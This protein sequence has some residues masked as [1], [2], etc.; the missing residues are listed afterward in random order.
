MT[1]AAI[2][3][4]GIAAICFGT[5]ILLMYK[6]VWP[7]AQ[8]WLML[9]AGLGMAG[10]MFGV[11]VDKLDVHPMAVILGHLS[12]KPQ[13]QL[14]PRTTP[15]SSRPGSSSPRAALR[16]SGTSP[17]CLSV[18][19]ARSSLT[20]SEDLPSTGSRSANHAKRI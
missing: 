2:G 12:S 15:R 19:T 9:V 4:G 6:R 14:A 11:L 3:F 10:G 16:S 20:S 17:R 8:P 18:V 7:K 1:L 13:R 5:A